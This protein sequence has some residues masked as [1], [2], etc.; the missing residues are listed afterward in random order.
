LRRV[1]LLLVALACCVIGLASIP[2]LA[3]DAR[4]DWNMFRREALHNACSPYAGPLLPAQKWKFTAGGSV[5]SSP[6]IG[7]DGTLYVG[8]DDGNL[9]AVNPDG[10]QKWQFA[11]AVTA[12]SS[13]AIASDGTI[14]VGSTD[15][16]LYAINPDGSEK[17]R[18]ATGG[19]IYGSAAIGSDGT[20]YIGSYDNNLYAVNPDG[21]EKWRFATG[22]G[23]HSSPAIGSDGIIYVGSFDKNLY[24]INPD[25]TQEWLFTT[26]GEIGSSPAIGADGTVYIGSNDNNL[27]AINPDGSQK[28]LFP[29]GGFVQSS[30]AIGSDGTIYVGSLD[31][32]LY[33]VNPDG[34]QKWQFTTGGVVDSSPA[35]DSDGTIYVGSNDNNLY[36]VNPDGTQKWLFAA[37]GQVDSSPAIGSDGTIYVGSNDNN[38]YAIE[39]ATPTVT[40]IAP[41]VAMNT[42]VVSITGLTGTNFATG[43]TVKLAM[44][45]QSDIAASHVA[46]ASSTQITCSFDLTGA[47]SG[48]WDVVVTNTDGRSGTLPGGFIITDINSPTV[49]V[50]QAADQADPTGGS[51]INF[52][53]E[54]S[55]PVDDF[56]TGDVTLS[57]TAGAT[58]AEV[59]GSG[60]TYNVAVRGMTGNGTVI[61]SIPVGVAHDA[62]GYVNLP[63]TSTDNQVE[64]DNVSPTVTIDQAEGQ[65]DPTSDLTISLTVFFSKPITD[66]AT[67]DVTLS[68]TAG[69]TTAVVTGSGTTYNVAVSG[70]TSGGTVIASIAEGVAHDSAGNA[71]EASSSTDN[72]VTFNPL[73]GD[74]HMFRREALH[75]ALSPYAG[76]LLPSQRWRSAAGGCVY[77]SPAIG[78]DGTIYVGSDDQNFYAVNPDG[79]QKWLF[80]AG[81]SIQSSPAIGL[82]GTIY[83]GS[84]DNNLYAV[85]S[86]GSEKWRF[87]TTGPI[88]SSP[89]IG[90]DGMIF[91]GSADGN[92]Y[93]INPEGAERWRFVTGGAI[94]SSA[95]VDSNGVVYVGSF[96][97]NLYAINPDG[98]QKWCFTT[99]LEVYSSPA[100]G[101]NGIIYVGSNDNNLYAVN[102]DGTQKWL[103]SA[104]G[105][106]QSSPAVGSDGTIYVGSNDNNLY[107]VNP[108][109]T[110]KWRFVT[111]GPVYSSPAIDA[112]GTVYVGSNDNNL[113]AVNPDGSEKWRFA[114]GLE[115][116]SS[117][118]IGSDGVIY[119]G[120]GDS[121]LYAIDSASPTVVSITPNSAPNSGTVNITD[122]AGT[123]FAA[124]AAVKL[125][126]TGE[127]AM[128]ATGVVVA[129]RSQI[130][131]SFDLKGKATGV[132]DVVVTNTDG[133]SGTLASAFTVVSSAPRDISLTPSGGT[134]GTSDD[135]LTSLYSDVNGASD[136]RRAYLLINDTT[137]QANAALFY[138]DRLAN[139]L[140]LK[141]DANTSWG[142]GYALGTNVTLENSQCFLYVKDTTES[143]DGNNLTVNWRFQLKA[144]FSTKSINGYMYVQDAG[145][146]TD[147]WSKMGI[148][149]NIK[150]QVVS[151]APNNEI[152]PIDTPTTLTSLYRDP[153]GFAD[154]RKCYMLVCE[155]FNQANSVFVWYDKS[156]NKVYLKNDANTSWGT[157]YT[158]STDITLS[159]SQCEVYVKD[160]VAAGSGTDLTVV[161]S[162]RLKPIMTERN[163]YSWMYVTDSKGLSDGWKKVGTHYALIAPACVGVTPSTG[164]VETITLQAGTPQLFTTQFVDNNGYADIYKCY[165]QLSVTSSQANAV[166]LLYDAKLKK[167]FLKNDKNT[168]WSAGYAPGT[169]V[170]L[171]NSQCTLHVIDTKVTTSDTY[172]LTI[173]WSITLKRGQFGKKLCE[174]TYIQDTELLNSGW[175][176][177]GYVTASV[178]TVSIPGGSLLMGNNGSEGYSDPSEL[179]QNSVELPDYTIGKYEVTR[180]QYKVFMSAGG[181]TKSAFWSTAGWAWKVNSARAQPDYWADTQDFSVDGSQPFTQTDDC[182][183]IGVTYYEAEA[184]CN[185]AGGHLPSEAEWEKAARWTGDHS[186]VYP[187][188][189]TWDAQK[190]NN[191]NDNNSAGGGSGR[192]QT[193][194]V[195]SYPDGI[196]PFGCFDMAGNALEWCRDSYK[197]YPGN[198]TPFDYTDSLGVL[199]GGSWYSSADISSRCAG[200]Y[201][202][203]PFYGWSDSGF[204]MAR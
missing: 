72:E 107:A 41:N 182:P 140:Y 16:N 89:A 27:Y 138:Y 200:R 6:A 10:T 115:V 92:I 106:V 29:T 105:P 64:Y 87:A 23:I 90:P 83:I 149:N 135:T 125:A 148:Y 94:H 168:A 203:D 85:K 177:D 124:G 198:E 18:F 81:G 173:D 51:P 61:V 26:G 8:S 58:T 21:T 100:V 152:L 50:N 13:P 7:S 79:T 91:V 57:G 158:A 28:W 36:A 199:R 5:Q 95:A 40:A 187:W 43:A 185:W 116:H 155:N 31:N 197:S 38:L 170:T 195:G 160:T 1:R 45:G 118:A 120:S 111:G 73:R 178:E 65:A 30:P 69:A 156:S 165:F 74:W 142:T 143:T 34:S 103:F 4:G 55:A 56:A 2:G 112:G 136:I 131:C 129:S 108:D 11:L 133:R 70:M 194:P 97:K 109:G 188:G 128:V 84:S 141:N 71:N 150:P 166:L 180:R 93:A 75:N 96:D 37:G 15:N 161:W 121:G 151:I 68:G 183:V 176:V 99:G 82:D 122:L 54:F 86:D 192:Y 17:W 39:S 184:F 169:N 130:T 22:N 3:D 78:S 139:R 47:A 20:V 113:Y 190:C 53:V 52:T 46:V 66:F 137:S 117:P 24:A 191:L 154:L 9:Y 119:V 80:A 126:K 181:Y 32:K 179:P 202:N 59:T 48:T 175:H 132:W 98:S 196:S 62:S 167:V 77:S 189:D 204:R 127:N 44:T 163:L 102:P 114:T 174:R 159:N 171:E 146:L 162:F 110:E 147:G 14:Y 157:G 33:A 145:G 193:A 164:Y 123:N 19:F 134:L 76:P 104:G 153:N 35:V 144:A 88:D 49:T 12:R 101:A 25:G 60:T 172:S 201:E 186:N 42:G 63:S 67:G